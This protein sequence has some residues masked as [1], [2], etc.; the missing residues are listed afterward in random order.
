M[1]Y[2]WIALSWT[3]R[4]WVPWV[5]LGN[6]EWRI[7]IS[8]GGN[9]PLGENTIHY[10][11]RL[12]TTGV[13]YVLICG[14]SVSLDKDKHSS[15]VWSVCI[16]AM[17]DTPEWQAL[18]SRWFNSTKFI[19]STHWWLPWAESSVSSN[20]V[21]YKHWCNLFSL[22]LHF[23]SAVHPLP[24]CLEPVT[25]KWR[26]EYTRKPGLLALS[27]GGSSLLCFLIIEGAGI[28]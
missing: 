21:A 16:Q 8:H 23:R 24:S 1:I 17:I 19:S 28:S 12:Y 20:K 2:V 18:N 27:S 6:S 15:T 14:L 25:T 11:V 10:Y 4:V 13:W 9:A 26:T 7:R 22:Q 5:T 3:F